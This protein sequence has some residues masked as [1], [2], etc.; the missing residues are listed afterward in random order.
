MKNIKYLALFLS[1]TLLLSCGEDDVDSITNDGTYSATSE[2]SIG[3]SDSNNDQLLLEAGG[4]VNFTIS[5]SVGALPDDMVISLGLSS[6]DGSVEA[7]FPA[8]L[9]IP[10]GDTSVDLTVTFADDGVAGDTETYTL[11]IT[12]AVIQGDTSEYYLTTAQQSRTINIVDFLPVVVVTTPSDVDFDF[13]W[14]GTSDLDCRIRDAALNNIDTGYSVTPGETVTLG[15]AD[16]DGVYTFSVRPWTVADPMVAYNIDFTSPAGTE[17]F[18]GTLTLGGGFWADEFT[19]LE[20][21]KATSGGQ[22]TYTF[23]EL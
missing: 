11:E 17:S 9:T 13:T 18:T 21:D 7:T 6:S 14:A 20:I 2:I 3:F 5:H 10:A 4:T 23:T 19:V 12:D 8:T 22:V 15:M 1:F 16:G